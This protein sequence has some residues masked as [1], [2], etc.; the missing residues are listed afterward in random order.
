MFHTHAHI[1]LRTHTFTHARRSTARRPEDRG[2]ALRL[3]LRTEA[4]SGR[5][6]PRWQAELR[7]QAEL[8]KT[9]WSRAG[10]EHHR[11]QRAA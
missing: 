10:M 4:R 1:H 2:P 9:G 5:L 11:S 8:E 7:T 3:R 6:V